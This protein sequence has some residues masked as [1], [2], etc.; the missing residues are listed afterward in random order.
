MQVYETI[1]YLLMPFILP[2][3]FIVQ[4]AFCAYLLVGTFGI[5]FINAF[6]FNYVHLR[7]KSASV[8]FTCLLYYMPYKS[9]LTLINVVSF[10]WSI[11]KYARYFATRHPKIVDDE[12]AVEVVLRLEDPD[13]W[14]C[15]GKGRRLTVTAVGVRLEGSVELRPISE[16]LEGGAV[17]DGQ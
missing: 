13:G 11:W 9:I 6:L 7:R 14:S 16:I 10:Y 8:S 1:L 17:Q 12:R 4:P 2:I 15:E 3:S 5:Y